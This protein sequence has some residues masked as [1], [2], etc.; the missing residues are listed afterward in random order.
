MSGLDWVIVAVLALSVLV[1]MAQ[2]FFF[3]IFSLAGALLGFGLA[4]WEYRRVAAWFQPYVREA[5]VADAAGFL[6]I[7][8]VVLLLAG[9]AARVSRWAVKEAGLAWADRLLGAAFG[10]VRGLV[11]VTVMVAAIAAFAPEAPSLQRS[12]LS[13]LFLLLGR[14]LSWA[15]PSEFRQALRDGVRRIQQAPAPGPQSRKP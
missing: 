9:I 15:G 8:F 7:F 4:A 10:L 12:E 13:P 2:G 3:E 14:A 1:A 6:T 11:V 5:W